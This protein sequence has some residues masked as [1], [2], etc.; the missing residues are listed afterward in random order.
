VRILVLTHEYPP[1]GGG[2]GQAA[3][4][5]CAGL[6]ARGH[7][8]QVLTAHH[9]NLAHKAELDGVTVRR[10]NSLRRLPFKASLTAMGGYVAAAVAAGQA[11]IRRFRPDLIHVHFAV[12]AGAAAYALHNLT[13]VPYV[14]TAHLGDVPGGVPEKTGRWFRY[15]YPLTPPIWKEAARVVAVSEFTRRLALERY[16][17]EIRVIP[18]GVDLSTLPPRETGRR[19]PRLAFAGRFVQQ[20][21]PLQVVRTLATLEDLGWSAVMIGDG[22]LMPQVRAEIERHQLQDRIELPGWIDPRDVLG[23]LARSD[24]L[25]MPTYTEGLPVVGVQA[26][27]LGLALAVST[28]PGWSDVVGEGNSLVMP[29]DDTAAWQF[30]LRTVLSEPNLLASMQAASL[31]LAP[32]FDLARVLDAYERLFGEVTG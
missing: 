5:I 14:L 6:A 18:N 29:P 4:D 17:V 30:G 2:G 32:R 27:G 13:R 31:Q 24:I 16:P 8:V 1:V 23:E 21:N 3:R 11:E 7:A 9:G 26:L 28:A 25:F 19:F 22:P 12:P 15:L 20:K 10:L